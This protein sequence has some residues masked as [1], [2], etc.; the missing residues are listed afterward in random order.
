MSDFDFSAA[1]AESGPNVQQLRV[2]VIL[3]EMDE[4]NAKQLR[5]ALEDRSIKAPVI[6]RALNKLGFTCTDNSVKSWRSRYLP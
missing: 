6:E 4:K 1:L 3:A 5:A 2:D